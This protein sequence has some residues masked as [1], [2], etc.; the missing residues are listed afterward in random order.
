MD[1]RHRCLLPTALVMFAV[2]RNPAEGLMTMDEQDPG[3]HGELV[4]LLAA[5]R[6]RVAILLT[7]A[8]IALYFGFVSLIAFRPDILA[9]LIMPGLSVGI[10]LGVAVIVL[11]WL[12]TLFYVRWTNKRY[13]A[14]IEALRGAEPNR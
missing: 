1:L 13:D 6:W 14:R 12:L 10:A 9:R 11:S 7:A 8:M 2:H 5:E 3:T 4:R